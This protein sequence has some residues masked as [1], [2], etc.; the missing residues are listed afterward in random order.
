MNVRNLTSHA[1]DLDDGSNLSPGDVVNVASSDR[2]KAFVADG[3]LGE[4]DKDVVSAPPAEPVAPAVTLANMAPVTA[5]PVNPAPGSTITPQTAAP[6]P[7]ADTAAAKE[8]T[9]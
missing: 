2:M 3:L 1:V 5:S 4:V 6:T 8:Q 7:A 9:A